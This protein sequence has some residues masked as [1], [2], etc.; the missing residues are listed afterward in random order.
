MRKSR[1]SIF[2]TFAWALLHGGVALS[3]AAAD[4]C[5]HLQLFWLSR[6]KFIKG[7]AG[8][9]KAVAT[10]IAGSA[11]LYHTNNRCFQTLIHGATIGDHPMPFRYAREYRAIVQRLTLALMRAGA[12]TSA[13]TSSWRTTASRCTTWWRTMG[14]TTMPTAR[15]TATAATTTS[16]GTGAKLQRCLHCGST[17]AC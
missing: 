7:D 11:D 12:P 13:S 6:R 16:P 4:F 9:K 3:L 17:N 2:E 15:A 1:T 8:M 10:R 5:T 14:S